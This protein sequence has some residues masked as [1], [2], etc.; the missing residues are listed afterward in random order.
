MI[1]CYARLSR[2]KFVV[3]DF[4]QTP[5]FIIYYYYI[6]FVKS[7][8]TTQMMAASQNVKLS[9]TLSNFPMEMTDCIWKH[10]K[11][12]RPGTYLAPLEIDFKVNKIIFSYIVKCLFKN[13]GYFSFF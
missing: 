7:M 10:E 4:R 6:N 1:S 2:K 12:A 13:R 5:F 11:Y 9:L 3:N 8:K